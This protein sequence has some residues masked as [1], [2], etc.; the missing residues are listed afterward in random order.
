MINYINKASKVL[1]NYFKHDEE[2]TKVVRNIEDCLIYLN[3]QLVIW[4][5]DTNYDDDSFNQLFTH[6]FDNKF[7]IY[8]IMNKKIDFKL[9][10]D[11]IIDYKVPDYP[12]YTLEFLVTFSISAKNWLSLDSYNILIV[13][14]DMSNPKILTLLCSILSYLNKNRLHPMDLYANMLSVI[15]F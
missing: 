10:Q 12:S 4:R 7:M 14:D 3:S 5:D 15:L 1:T 6:R 11:K 8:N 13:H 9:N 2:V